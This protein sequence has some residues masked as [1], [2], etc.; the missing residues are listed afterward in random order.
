MHLLSP[1][2]A[3]LVEH[4]SHLLQLVVLVLDGGLEHSFFNA[5]L[6]ALFQNGLSFLLSRFVLVV[7]NEVSS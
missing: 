7:R 6:D 3:V 5:F 2:L 4:L 1:P